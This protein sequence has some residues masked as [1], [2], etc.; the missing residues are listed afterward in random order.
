MLLDMLLVTGPKPHP[1]QQGKKKR[2][3]QWFRF[4]T[5]LASGMDVGFYS[6]TKMI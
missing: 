5:V 1:S 2:S 4:E 3:L 6:G